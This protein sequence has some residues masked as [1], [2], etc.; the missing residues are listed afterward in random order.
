MHSIS[1]YASVLIA[2]LAFQVMSRQNETSLYC[3]PLLGCDHQKYHW[4]YLNMVIFSV[5]PVIY[6]ISLFLIIIILFVG[7]VWYYSWS[8]PLLLP[9]IILLDVMWG[10]SSLHYNYRG[11]QQKKK[12]HQQLLDWLGFSIG[13]CNRSCHM[14]APRIWNNN[15]VIIILFLVLLSLYSF[16]FIF[17]L[18]ED[19]NI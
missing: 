13:D 17:C 10:A 4:F 7:I 3:V 9:L 14:S 12:I 18:N 15:L 16:I 6:C 2:H 19:L 11:F 1:T 8:P 5:F